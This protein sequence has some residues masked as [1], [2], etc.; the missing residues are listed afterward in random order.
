[1]EAHE[2]RIEP[3]DDGPGCEIIITVPREVA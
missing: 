2:G 3:G 1:M